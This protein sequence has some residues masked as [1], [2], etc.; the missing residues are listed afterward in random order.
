MAELT[1]DCC[2]SAI[3]ASCCEPAAKPGCCG[4]GAHTGGSCG[5][6]AGA[7][8]QTNLPQTPPPPSMI[9]VSS[10]SEPEPFV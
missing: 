4:A 10:R 2:T 8:E 3:Q 1:S 7:A 6:S 5:C 9:T